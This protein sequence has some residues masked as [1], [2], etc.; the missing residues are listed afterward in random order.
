MKSSTAPARKPISTFDLPVRAERL[1]DKVAAQIQQ[2]MRSGELKTGDKLPPERELVERMGVSRT[3]VREAVRS[4]AAKG[5][6]DA[7]SGGGTIV[8][9]PSSAVVSEMMT[10]MLHDHARANGKA[11]Q[12][13]VSFGHLQEVRRH[14]EVEIAGLAA[15]RRTSA[16]LAKLKALL[17]SLV[18]NE[19]DAAL[20]ARADVNFHAAIAHATHNPLYPVLLGSIADML[21]AVRLLATRLPST[22]K[23]AL[24]HH[25]RIFEQLSAGS[26]VG[27][28]AAMQAHLAEAEDTYQRARK[29][30]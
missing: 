1:S 8:L 2:M 21:M 7:R 16:D 17:G 27:A 23:N 9:A 12:E 13:E 28:R 15:A 29:A 30:K 18:E 19:P 6:L 3:V 5:L 14:L 10:M 26:I 25:T 24:N 20:W 4:L 22:R 11:H